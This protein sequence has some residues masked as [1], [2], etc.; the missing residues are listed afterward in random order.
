MGNRFKWVLVV[1]AAGMLI[2]SWQAVAQTSKKKTYRRARLPDFSSQEKNRVFFE[3][4]FS[5]LVGKRPSASSGRQDPGRPVI[6]PPESPPDAEPA[7]GVLWSK[8]I[9]ATTLEDEIKTLKLELDKLITTPSAFA[10][11]GYKPARQSFSLLAM[12]FAIIEQY[13][14]DVRWKDDAAAARDMFARTAANLKAGGSIQVYN[15]AKQ[16]KL[17]LD[18]LVRGSRLQRSGEEDK[19]W[20]S[21]VDRVPLMQLLESR[22]EPNL[23][24]WTNSKS[25]FNKQIETVRREAELVVAIAEVLMAEEMD[26][27]ADDEYRK[28]AQLLKDGGQAVVQAVKSQ[29]ETL[30]EKG[31]S[32]ISRSCVDC[33]DSYR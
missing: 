5:I 31:V 8:L 33:H 19:S 6:P 15:E 12:L 26:D 3:D 21:I 24:Q 13:D 9:S 27:A 23:K 22:F 7:D 18:D 10:G 1:V 29:D 17:D 20:E 30:A 16:R 25:E 11:R 2:G 32:D 28:F 4:V 14:S